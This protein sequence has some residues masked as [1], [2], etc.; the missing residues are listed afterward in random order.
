MVNPGFNRELLCYNLQIHNAG[1]T[2][3]KKNYL[4][5][6]GEKFNY[7]RI[8]LHI[9]FLLHFKYDLIILDFSQF[10]KG[11]SKKDTL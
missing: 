1:G 3:G 10:A 2:S 6:K 9:F 8:Y 11:R 5:Q 7:R 4:N